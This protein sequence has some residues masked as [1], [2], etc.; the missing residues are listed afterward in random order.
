M[1][2]SKNLKVGEV[3]MH[4][5]AFLLSPYFSSESRC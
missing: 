1:S 3:R 2:F 5:G 4:E